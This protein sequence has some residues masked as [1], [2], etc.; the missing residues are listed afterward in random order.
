MLLILIKHRRNL[1]AR[2]NRPEEDI[3]ATFDSSVLDSALKGDKRTACGCVAELV[4]YIDELFFGEP[5]SD[6]DELDIFQ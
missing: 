4:A 5:K 1:P 6:L 2:A 3:I